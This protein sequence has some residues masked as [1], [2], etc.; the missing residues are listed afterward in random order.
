MWFSAT[1]TTTSI[2]AGRQHKWR[3]TDLITF[4]LQNMDPPDIEACETAKALKSVSYRSLENSNMFCYKGENQK[5]LQAYGGHATSVSSGLQIL[6]DGHI[7]PGEGFCG[8]G[9]YCFGTETCEEADLDF[10]WNRTLSG[11]YNYGALFLIRLH[12]ICINKLEGDIPN[13]AI[14]QHKD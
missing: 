14:A 8:T 1:V 5:R 10:L 13:G 9:I 12:G 4:T 2:D 7:N 3:S 6:R 11:C